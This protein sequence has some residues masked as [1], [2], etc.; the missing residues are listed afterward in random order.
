MF[1]FYRPSAMT[2]AATLADAP[3]NLAQILIFCIIIASHLRLLS[4][5]LARLLIFCPLCS[6]SWVVFTRV[7]ER[8]SRSTSTSQLCVA[9]RLFLVKPPTDTSSFS[10][11][12]LAL[13]GFFRLLGTLCQNYDQA[14][15]LASVIITIMVR[16][17]LS[18]PSDEY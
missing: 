15:R 1:A 12:F 9:L 3:N 4:V 7:L 6:T 11:G 8:S 17:F 14:S 2:I 13:A 5:P 16:F 18:T 10:Q